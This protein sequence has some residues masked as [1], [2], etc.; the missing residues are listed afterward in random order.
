MWRARTHQDYLIENHDLPRTENP[1]TLCAC[2]RREH[3][4]MLVDL[5]PMPMEVRAALGLDQVDFLCDGCQTRLFRE[6]HISEEEFYRLLG[7]PESALA[8]HR[9]VDP[10]HQSGVGGR[11]DHMKPKHKMVQH[12]DVRGKPHRLVSSIP[13]KFRVHTHQASAVRI[14]RDPHNDIQLTFKKK[15]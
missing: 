9:S 15:Q 6:L 13:L 5:T 2:G 3:A 4:D 10:R 14:H 1:Q 8:I 11:P 12:S 7:A